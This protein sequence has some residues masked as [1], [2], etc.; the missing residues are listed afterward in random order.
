VKLKSEGLTELHQMSEK[1]DAVRHQRNSKD[2]TLIKSLEEMRSK[3][4][5]RS[6]SALLTA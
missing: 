3:E 5:S 6:K 4:A 2:E 1:F